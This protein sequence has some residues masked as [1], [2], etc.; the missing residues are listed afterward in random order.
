M[1]DCCTGNIV[2]RRATDADYEAVMRIVEDVIGSDG[3]DYI[4]ATY[5]DLLH[6]RQH[7]SYVAETSDTLKVVCNLINYYQI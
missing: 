2:I 7:V 3:V 5:H 6:D 4:P 1:S